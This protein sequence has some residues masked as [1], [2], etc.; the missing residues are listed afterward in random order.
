MSRKFNVYG[1]GNALVD[2]QF[3]VEPAFLEKMGIDKGVM[4]LVDEERQV[5]LLSALS[6]LPS[7]RS[8]GGS[9]ANTMIGVV[10]LGGTAVYGCKV[11]DDVFGEFFVSDMR[12]GGVACDPKRS[13]VGVTGTCLVL[14]TP[15]ADRTMNT[16]LGITSAFGP[17]QVDPAL[18]AD[19]DYV[20]IEGYLLTSDSGLEAALTSQKLARDAGTRVAL[21]LSDPSV[22]Q[23]F[24]ERMKKVVAAGV[25]LL[26]CNE[27]EARAYTGCG[28]TEEA[29]EALGGEVPMVAATCG[30]EGALVRDGEGVHR[31]SPFLVEAVDTNGAGDLFAGAFL[32]G[33]TAGRPV[34]EAGKLAAYASSRVVAQYGPRLPGS[35]ADRIPSILAS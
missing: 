12:A 14:I 29:L 27:A 33:L 31:I 16:F 2:L 24:G 9:A 22:V 25:D 1:I 20:Y 18:V 7:K 23:A 26:F 15:D 10:Q 30:P 8:S 17:E 4:T 11:A 34:T 3:E 5:M 19:A 28:L 32:A 35:L 13:P 6:H 21:T